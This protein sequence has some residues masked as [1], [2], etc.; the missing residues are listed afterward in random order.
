M[1]RHEGGSA[2]TDQVHSRAEVE[3]SKDEQQLQTH[4]DK[5]QDEDKI[6]QQQ[7]VR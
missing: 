5:W 6:N 2:S 1:L 4:H 7:I 3:F